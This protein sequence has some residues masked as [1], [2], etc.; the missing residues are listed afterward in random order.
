MDAPPRV[1]DGLQRLKG[2][3]LMMPGTQL[4]V[5]EAARL[6][7]LH[8]ATLEAML[9]ALEDV[10]FLRRD[11]DGLYRRAFEDASDEW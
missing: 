11:G 5:E 3:F 2:A 10:R 1:V 8:S 7:G 4:S 6:S 9:H